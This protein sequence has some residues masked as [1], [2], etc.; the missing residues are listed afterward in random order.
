MALGCVG[1]FVTLFCVRS[2][3]DS[4]EVSQV[5]HLTGAVKIPGG[6]YIG[7]YNVAVTPEGKMAQICQL[8]AWTPVRYADMLSHRVWMWPVDEP[9][10]A[11]EESPQ[12]RVW[13]WGA[14]AAGVF[15]PVF[16]F[17]LWKR[18]D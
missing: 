14:L 17:Y 16:S 9:L 10:F 7:L 1:L 2:L 11:Y 18:E 13:M 8:V 15:L 12:S 3:G 5:F 6:P 4:C